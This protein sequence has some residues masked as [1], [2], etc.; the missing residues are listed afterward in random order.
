MSSPVAS[1]VLRASVIRFFA[2]CATARPGSAAYSSPPSARRCGGA[3]PSTLRWFSELSRET[4][5]QLD[6]VDRSHKSRRWIVD[7]SMMSLSWRRWSAAR[8]TDVPNTVILLSLALQ[9]ESH[10]FLVSPHP[11]CLTW[12]LH[13]QFP[14]MPFSLRYCFFRLSGQEF[15]LHSFFLPSLECFLKCILRKEPF[16]L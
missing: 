15:G 4:F 1:A 5:F 8:S 6:S 3:L 9:S 16:D 10:L 2:R 12:H 14:A 11:K 7:R 13:W